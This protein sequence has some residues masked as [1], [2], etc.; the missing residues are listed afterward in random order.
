MAKKK[1]KKK[2]KKVGKASASSQSKASPSTKEKSAPK[3]PTKKTPKE[4]LTKRQAQRKRTK[5][6]ADDSSSFSVEGWVEKINKEPRFRGS[7]QVSFANELST[8]YYLR[9]PSGVLSLD[10]ATG[11]GF[12]AGGHAQIYASESVGKT[13]LAFQTAG[14]VQKN[15]GNDARILIVVTEIR[16]DK[17]FARKAK[18]RVAYSEEEVEHYSFIRKERGLPPFT[19]EDLEDLLYQPGKVVIVTADTGEKSL[20]IAYDALEKGLFQLVII[21]SLGALLSSDQQA[22]DVGDRTY[23]GSS[24]MLTNFMNKVYPLFIMDRITEHGKGKGKTIERKMLETTLIGINQARAVIGAYG[25]QKKERAAAGAFAWKHAQLISIELNKSSAIK[26]SKDGKAIGREIRWELTKGK[27]GTHDGLKGKYDF[28]HVPRT[29]PVFWRDVELNGS[30]WG[31]DTITDMVHAAA[32]CGVI[33]VSG[34]WY[35]WESGNEVVAKAQ[36]EHGFADILVNSDELQDRLKEECFAR[37][38]LQAKYR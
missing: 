16:T 12:H 21:E 17:S 29:D 15:Y 36:G 23:G 22:G 24:V 19:D 11:G 1:L 18:F 27:A 13:Y 10:L 14:Q 33:Q 8:P 3:K 34:S 32:D 26:N 9:R 7:A 4:K 2:L 38:E 28:Y 6:A 5:D 20:D 31:I 25:K 37:V 35:S 30:T